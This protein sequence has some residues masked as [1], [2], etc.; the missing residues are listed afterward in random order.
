[1]TA[2]QVANM[3]GDI[4]PKTSSFFSSLA[5][6]WSYGIQTA[7][8]AAIMLVQVPREAALGFFVIGLA[9]VPIKRMTSQTS[10]ISS[11]IVPIAQNI[12][13]TFYRIVRSSLLIHV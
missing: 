2:S 4:L 10:K 6:L 11:V 3:A 8:L 9:A 1:M 5:N 13:R 12:N 7:M